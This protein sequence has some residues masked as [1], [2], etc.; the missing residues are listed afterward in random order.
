[1]LMRYIQHRYQSELQDVEKV[2]L[3]EQGLFNYVKGNTRCMP[4]APTRPPAS[5]TYGWRNASTAR[6]SR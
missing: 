4:M 5:G 2:D 3:H 6:T 1:M